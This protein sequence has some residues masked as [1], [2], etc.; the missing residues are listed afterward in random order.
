V[1]LKAAPQPDEIEELGRS[2]ADIC[3]RGTIEASGP[4]PPEVADDDHLDLPRIVFEFDRLNFGRLRL[5]IDALNALPS[6]PPLAPPHPD[7]AHAAAS[8]PDE[9][10]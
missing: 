6:A 5:L 4:L 7:S 10:E 9:G 8:V 2:F 3:A 1:R